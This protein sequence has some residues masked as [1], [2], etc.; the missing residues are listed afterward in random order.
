[1]SS[2]TSVEEVRK[3]DKIRT[4]L[5]QCLLD[6]LFRERSAVLRGLQKR[7]LHSLKKIIIMTT[8]KQNGE[9]PAPC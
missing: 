3:G 1:M 2:N 6:K 5:P 8:S 7:C 4:L 9:K